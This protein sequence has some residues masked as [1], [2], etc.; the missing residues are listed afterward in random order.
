MK[1]IGRKMIG[2]LGDAVHTLPGA[3]DVF[4][5]AADTPVTAPDPPWQTAFA[6]NREGRNVI[7]PARSVV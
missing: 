3:G 6:R 1:A 5:D 4:G 2:N 7:S